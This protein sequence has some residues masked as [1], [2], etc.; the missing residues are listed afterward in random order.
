ML[1]NTASTQAP[2]FAQLAVQTQMVPSF[3]SMME[4]AVMKTLLVATAQIIF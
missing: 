4:F 2:S 1:A 3:A